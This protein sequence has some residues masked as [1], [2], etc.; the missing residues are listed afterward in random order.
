[1]LRQGLVICP[2]PHPTPALLN[3]SARPGR[4]VR[5][6]FRW[7]CD[8]GAGQFRFMKYICY[9]GTASETPHEVETRGC[10]RVKCEAPK[11]AGFH[12]ILGCQMW[13]VGDGEGLEITDF[14]L[15]QQRGYDQHPCG[16]WSRCPGSTNS[17]DA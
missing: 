14:T 3:T 6:G 11:P 17:I 12:P 4:L 9:C 1:M 10:Q 13:D 2:W 5:N 8:T 15:R 16:N 7:V